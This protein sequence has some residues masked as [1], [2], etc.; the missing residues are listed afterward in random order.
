MRFPIRISDAD[1]PLWA[2]V[3]DKAA[4]ERL[5]IN[6]IILLLL[7]AWVAGK[8]KIGVTRAA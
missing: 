6:T 5:S 8:V 7:R 3:Q 1:A 4:A 2:E